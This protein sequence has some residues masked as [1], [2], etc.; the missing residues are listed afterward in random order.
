METDVKKCYFYNFQYNFQYGTKEQQQKHCKQYKLWYNAENWLSGLDTD[1]WLSCDPL[2]HFQQGF[3]QTEISGE[4][5]G[6]P[7]IPCVKQ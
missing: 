4:I 2:Q 3:L 1:S 5:A 7:G 6:H